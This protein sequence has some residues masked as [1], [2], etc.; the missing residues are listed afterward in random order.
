MSFIRSYLSDIP[1]KIPSTFDCL[2]CLIDES[3]FFCNSC[4]MPELPEVETVKV[5]LQ[6]N[7]INQKTLS[8]KIK[9]KNL[10]FIIN[11]DISQILSNSNITKISRRGKYLLF[12]YNNEHT[13]LFHLGMTGFF[14]IEKKY[15]FRKH[16][17]LI[18]N[19][20]KEKLI[21]N[22][23]RKFGFVKIFN[24]EEI[25][26]CSHLKNLGPEPLSSKFCYEYFKRNL[27]RRTNI[28]NL[29]MNQSFVAGLGNI[30]CSEILF[31]S[32]IKPTRPLKFIKDYEI[33][34]IV[35]SVKDI[36]LN[37]IK[38][39]GTTIKNFIVSDEKIGYF[40]NKLMVY[41]RNGMS[42]LKCKKKIVKI[43]QSG[44]STFFCSQCQK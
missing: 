29:L 8:V 28:K 30:Y 10:R 4:D 27:N 14:R 44:R 3:D 24:N 42:C 6:K 25:L 13:L 15:E 20:I 40:K 18:F 23:I 32:N 16:D 37:S 36:L 9:N 33:N 22:D 34:K 39:G 5:F 11:K 43:T 21:F 26:N 19:F 7:V 41:G 2:S 17:H 31:R 38:L 35:N 12:L 1:E